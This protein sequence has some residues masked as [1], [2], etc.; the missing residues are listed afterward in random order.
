[1]FG[2]QQSRAS[3]SE[4]QNLYRIVNGSD[5]R[6][7]PKLPKGALGPKQIAWIEKEIPNVKYCA[8]AVAA[9]DASSANARKLAHG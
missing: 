2:K 7:A 3:T 5:L 8:A 9:R 4:A 1:M 6:S